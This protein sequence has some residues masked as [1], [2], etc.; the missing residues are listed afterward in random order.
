M[1]APRMSHPTSGEGASWRAQASRSS[2][3]LV[4]LR[5]LCSCMIYWSQ[6]SLLVR[7]T[8]VS[9]VGLRPFC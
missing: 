9:R 4:F 7:I 8:S 3:E 5:Q 1:S 2:R 6:H